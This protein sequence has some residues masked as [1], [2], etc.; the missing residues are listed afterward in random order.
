MLR[1]W[2]PDTQTKRKN[3][4]LFYLSKKYIEILKPKLEKRDERK[5]F[6]QKDYFVKLLFYLC[7]F[8]EKI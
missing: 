8:I 5:K 6:H 7:T 1:A 2:K 4:T 3:S